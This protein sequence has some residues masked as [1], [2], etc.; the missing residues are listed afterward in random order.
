M[1]SM[2]FVK[3]NLIGFILG[4]SGDILGAN[5]PEAL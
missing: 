1:M 2:V 4:S 3:I 5:T